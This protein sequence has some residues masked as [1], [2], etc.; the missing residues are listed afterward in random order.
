MIFSTFFCSHDPTNDY[1][2]LFSWPERRAI[3]DSKMVHRCTLSWCVRRG[4]RARAR[5][6]ARLGSG[7]E[8]KNSGE[9]KPLF[10]PFFKKK[11]AGVF[12]SLH[13]SVPLDTL[14][15]PLPG[16]LS[17]SGAAAGCP[18]AP[19]CLLLIIGGKIGFVQAL[20]QAP[21]LHLAQPRELP[22]Q[23]ASQTIWVPD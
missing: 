7:L 17:S 23:E 6:P 20:L 12:L 15:H 18:R 4:G 16:A 21:L 3:R 5:I 2:F 11:E 9:S 19:C 8:L 13:S 1:F 22:C 10:L 14:E